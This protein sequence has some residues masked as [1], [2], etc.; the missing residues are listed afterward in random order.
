MDFVCFWSS[1]FCCGECWKIFL[2]W[3]HFS[4]SD[5]KQN[6]TQK[7]VFLAAKLESNFKLTSRG[8]C[9]LW[10]SSNWTDCP[11]VA[12]MLHGNIFWK[13]VA[14]I[15]LFQMFSV[16]T[17][18]EKMNISICSSEKKRC[19]I[20]VLLNKFLPVLFNVFVFQTQIWKKKNW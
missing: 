11:A 12:P 17:Q 3:N 10:S 9:T 7:C 16:V 20:S 19:L 14:E 15:C 5:R 13:L 2:T 4:V 6:K 18:E 1:W 8:I